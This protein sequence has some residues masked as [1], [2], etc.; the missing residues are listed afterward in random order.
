MYKKTFI[1]AI[2]VLAL[3][4]SLVIG[5]EFVKASPKTI[6]VPDNYPT[7]Q[8]A[9]ANASPGD[10]VFVRSGNY[11]G[12]IVI[13]KP[14]TLQGEDAKTTTIVG[15]ATAID[16][17]LT[18]VALRNTSPTSFPAKKTFEVTNDATLTLTALAERSKIQPANFIP[19]L[20]FA[21]I[22]N[23]NDVTISGFTIMGGD[24]AIYSSK[25]N[26][27]Q[28]HKNSLGTCILGGSNNTVANN[29]RIGLTIG[30][31]NNLIANNSGGLVLS[32]S[33]STIM[34]NSLGGFA[35]Q[36]AYS[37]II[38]NNT[39]SGSN[40]GLWIGSSISSGPPT[41]SYNLFAGNKIENCGLWGVLM[42]AGSYNVFFGNIV[43]NTGAGLDHDGYGLALG[44]NGLTSE[45]NLF[46]HNIF[47]NNV[48]NFGVNWPV[49]GSN[50]F[51]DG[52]E[53]NY[54]DDYLTRYPNATEVGISGTGNTSYVLTE[55][56][57]DNH[58]LMVQSTIESKVIALPQ[59]WESLMPDRSQ[60]PN[61]WSYVSSNQSGLP[62]VYPTQSES[63]TTSPSPSL[64]I[65]SSPSS[66]L[67]SGPTLTPS[68]TIPEFPSWVIIALGVVSAFLIICMRRGNEK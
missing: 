4:I 66:S 51:D 27:L 13:D 31:Y 20:T 30:G 6:T 23:S 9:I 65:T 35:L 18:S 25:A 68:S 8:D 54:W 28:I 36:S 63:P 64:S 29:S 67:T 15:A 59:P 45:N 56:N 52:K 11:R 41:C 40:M 39:L 44:G 5:A 14:L 12:G 61:Q 33:N 49:T 3:V 19:P 38:V 48:K 53:G 24:R 37:N 55:N 1:A 2:A 21:I 34:G 43:E 60:L 17:D 32:S 47:K 58:P 62:S 42:G 26:G 7:I 22:V 16:L 10:M 46:L 57:I 50:S